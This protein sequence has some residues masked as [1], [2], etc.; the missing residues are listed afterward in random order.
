MRVN[1][2][3][4]TLVFDFMLSCFDNGV[5][6]LTLVDLVWGGKF[7]NSKIKNFYDKILKKPSFK[8]LI[9]LFSN[10]ESVKSI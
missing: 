5:L 1:K 2:K 7:T 10:E 6:K 8:K 3:I 4:L 9:Q